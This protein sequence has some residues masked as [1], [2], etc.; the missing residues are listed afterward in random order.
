M[1][2]FPPKPA[3]YILLYNVFYVIVSLHPPPIFE[4]RIQYHHNKYF[5]IVR[6]LYLE[7]G[8]RKYW[9]MKF[10]AEA[11]CSHKRSVIKF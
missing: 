3:S 5:F 1:E 9:L 11:V 6:Q 10:S 4:E 2:N 7:R 8:F